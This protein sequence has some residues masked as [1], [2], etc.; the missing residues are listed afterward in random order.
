M[1]VT[2]IIQL[3]VNKTNKNDWYT[4]DKYDVHWVKS[5]LTAWACSANSA[6]LLMYSRRCSFSIANSWT[7][8]SAISALS[9]MAWRCCSKFLI[10]EGVCR[11]LPIPF[12]K[13]CCSLLVGRVHVGGVHG[14][15]TGVAWGETFSVLQIMATVLMGCKERRK[16][17]YMIC[18][19]YNYACCC[20]S[21]NWN[22]I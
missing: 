12:V 7:F 17:T 22:C 3:E 8:L 21:W 11:S 1:I 15:G 16:T 20:L 6:I 5:I 13:G 18:T 4:W 10:N 2:Y 9:S 14:G 19:Y